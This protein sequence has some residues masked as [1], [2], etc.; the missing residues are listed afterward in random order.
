MHASS[1]YA[2]KAQ[3]TYL[4]PRSKKYTSR[5]H[6]L[7]PLKKNQNAFC[8]FCKLSSHYRAKSVE[9]RASHSMAHMTSRATRKQSRASQSSK[10]RRQGVLA[11]CLASC[12]HTC[13]AS[14]TDV[15]VSIVNRT[16]MACRRTFHISRAQ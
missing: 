10:H 13:V 3:R 15:R 7:Q 16:I 1:V 5:M 4:C 9:G 6:A 8:M 12:S 2:F 11:F 14:T